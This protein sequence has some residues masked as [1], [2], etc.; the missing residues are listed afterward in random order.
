MSLVDAL[1]AESSDEIDLKADYD[2]L[3]DLQE[4][5]KSESAP[6]PVPITVAEAFAYHKILTGPIDSDQDDSDSDDDAEYNRA[7]RGERGQD[8]APATALIKVGPHDALLAVAEPTDDDSACGNGAPHDHMWAANPSFRFTEPEVGFLSHLAHLCIEARLQKCSRS[9]C[10]EERAR[11][12]RVAPDCRWAAFREWALVSMSCQASM[13][14]KNELSQ[15]HTHIARAISGCCMTLKAYLDHSRE[16]FLPFLDG[17]GVEEHRVD[18]AEV[19]NLIYWMAKI[20]SQI[21]IGPRRFGAWDHRLLP[22]TVSLPSIERAAHEVEAMGLC[23]QRLWNLVAISDRRQS[24]LPDIINALRPHKDSL[25]HESHDFCTPSKCQWSHMN[26]SSVRQLHKCGAV[27]PRE[28]SGGRK[29]ARA[30]KAC[31]QRLFSVELLET[32]VEL[33][34]STAWLCSGLR[35][36]GPRDAYIAISHVWSDGTG[37]GVQEVG[38]VNSCLFDFFS[39]IAKELGCNGLWWDALSIPYEPRARSKALNQMHANYANARYTVVH[40]SYLINFP[41]SDDGSPCLAIVLS[42]WFTRGWTALELAMSKRVKVLFGNPDPSEKDPVIKDLDEDVLAASP[43]VASRAHWLATTLIRRLRAS[44]NDVGDLLAILSPRSTSWARDRTII[45]A[46]L[47]GVPDCDFTVGESIITSKIL[48]Y[49][50]KIPYGCILHGKPTMRDRGEFSWCAATLDDMPPGTS[51]D[52]G[53]G[54]GSRSRA[55]LDLDENGAIEGPFHARCLEPGE[56]DVN[57]KPFGNDLAVVVKVNIAL[58]HHERCLLL[59]QDPSAREPLALLVVPISIIRDGPVL[60]CRYIGTVTETHD[61]EA[62]DADDWFKLNVRLGGSDSHRR[63]MRADKA[64]EL[65]DDFCDVVCDEQDDKSVRGDEGDDDNED[66]GGEQGD[67]LASVQTPMQQEGPPES[68]PEWPIVNIWPGREN[69]QKA[70]EEH[71]ERGLILAMTKR[72]ENAARYLVKKKVGLQLDDLEAIRALCKDHPAVTTSGMKMLGDIYVENDNLQ[73]ASYIYRYV[74]ETYEAIEA[75]DSQQ[76]FQLYQTKHSLGCVRFGRDEVMEAKGLFEDVLAGCD[77]RKKKMERE[78]KRPVR[79]RA[80]TAKKEAAQGPDAP[81]AAPG[82]P[83]KLSN[84]AKANQGWYRLEL[85]SITELTLLKVGEVDFSGAAKTYRRALRR[86]GNAPKEIE[87]F[88]GL[89]VGRMSQVFKEKSRRD[90]RAA[91]VYQRALKRFDTMFRMNHLLIPI[92]ALHLGVNCMLRS[93]FADAQLYLMRALA[94][95]FE[96]FGRP[97]RDGETA[98]EYQMEDEREHLILVLVRY[99]LGLLFTKQQK[100][101]D[102]QRQFDLALAVVTRA[103]N[104]GTD[105]L[106]LSILNALGQNSL[107]SRPPRLDMA[108]GYFSQVESQSQGRAEQQDMIRLSIQAKLGRARSVY[109]TGKN[110]MDSAVRLLNAIIEQLDRIRTEAGNDL[111]ECQVRLFLGRVFEDKRKLPDAAKRVDL[112]LKSLKILEGEESLT[113]LEAAS[114]LGEIYERL[115]E[116]DEAETLLQMAADNWLLGKVYLAQRRLEEAREKVEWA[117]QGCEKALGGSHKQT[118]STAQTLGTIHLEMNKLAEAQEMYKKAYT[119][120]KNMAAKSN[121]KAHEE[122]GLESKLT[123]KT[124]LLALMDYAKVCALIPGK[125]SKATALS[126]YKLAV[127]G[128]AALDSGDANHKGDAHL[129]LLEAKLSLGCV[130][131]EMRKFDEAY[132]QIREALAGFLSLS[133]PKPG[134]PET[135][136]G[137]RAAT[138][139][140]TKW[141]EARLR[142]GQLKLDAS[143]QQHEAQEG[144]DEGESAKEL[145]KGGPRWS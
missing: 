125:R 2:C 102:A 132:E 115:D 27:E 103:N 130:Y 51:S 34:N 62:F 118:A 98:L 133:E 94:G 78:S 61:A 145:I 46:L 96:R 22:S 137:A 49:L 140:R 89:W 129:H 75:K 138:A 23:K 24:D 111:D 19:A 131:R 59:R 47:T 21:G 124:T 45:A 81:S 54:A 86:F 53:G 87:A 71:H 38:T 82:S 134:R 15:A 101:D 36:S 113:Y 141:F 44:I 43:A 92:T 20:Q 108:E 5:D 3:L 37:V 120:F 35:L 32:A 104:A 76:L 107:S 121:A 29:A 58:R 25:R 9:S 116:K 97:L 95:F 1:L 119:G 26:S 136:V 117:Y 122:G 57:I 41:W 105:V 77:E 56:V 109:S 60:K 65:Y 39:G 143:H 74:I 52:V 42:T 69:R 88:E 4:Q 11:M 85:D 90:E 127:E 144:Q 8:S 99:H 17:A 68:P 33:G 13:R 40:D 139:A 79:F 80:G 6:P 84:E 16:R 83:V 73:E 70:N 48:G 135:E 106:R 72:N 55:L 123:D 12:D 50:G 67:D 126:K 66:D 28:P 18:L 110:G 14:D 142:L 64:L 114:K 128:F 63:G 112:A 93:K 91:G 31:A 30:A 7:T 100:F 10:L